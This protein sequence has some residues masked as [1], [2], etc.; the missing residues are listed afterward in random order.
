MEKIKKVLAIGLSL[1]MIFMLAGCQTQTVTKSDQQKEN[2]VIAG[3]AQG[4]NG[5]IKLE[6][7][8]EEDAI[9]EIQIIEHEESDFTISVFDQLPEAMIAANST[10]VDTITGATVTSNALIEAVKKAIQASGVTLVAKGQDADQNNNKVEDTSTDIV[11]IGSG[12]AGLTAAIEATFEGA[13][14]IV[15]EKNPFMGGNTNY[16]TGGMNAAATKHQEAQGVEDSAE[17]FYEDTMAGGHDKNDPELLKVF[18]EGSAASI[19]WLED[20]GAD[21]SKI[22]RLGGQSVDRTHTTSDGGAVGAHLMSVFEKNLEKLDIDV[23]I[24]TKAVEILAEENRVT[25]IV[26]ETADGS[27]YT[28][29]A[30]AV[31][32]ASG[33]FGA[34][35]EMVTKF[36]PAYAGFG[37]TNNPGAT[38]D[39]IKMVEKL[40]AALVNPEYIQTHPTVVAGGNIMITEGTRG[41]GA[42]LINREGKRFINE[43]ETRDTVS[44][45]ILEQEGETAFLVFDENVPER[46]AA[47]RKYSTN[48]VLIEADSLANLAEKI[49]V[50]SE[51]LEKTIT[52]YNGYFETQLDTAFERRVIAGQLEKAPFYAVEVAPAIHHTMGGL[53]INTS[54][55]VINNSGDVVE[56]LFA[57]GEVTG[58]LHGD[59]RLGGNAV[60]DIVIFGRVA[61]KTAAQSIQ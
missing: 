35:Q 25:G 6:V 40:D 31:I 47:V 11:I 26:V 60:A 41:E 55:Q 56:G 30:K 1:S 43:L 45:A 19:D 16:A 18:T 7:T 52:E 46:L 22:S 57:A 53:K 37:T 12:G 15:V 28:I 5:P 61:G 9:K 8:I 10:D 59:N 23:R 20:L 29:H 54:A 21:L 14:V 4:H 38:G 3:E 13:E 36:N 24:N 49:G 39:A 17:L 58:G 48:G 34:S 32:I 44:K 42:I 33:G 50:N 2:Q 51:E 27:Q